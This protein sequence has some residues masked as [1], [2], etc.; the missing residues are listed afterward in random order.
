MK[1]E[2]QDAQRARASVSPFL[3]VDYRWKIKL[4]SLLGIGQVNR[5]RTA[6]R[7]RDAN[8]CCVDAAT[9]SKVSLNADIARREKN[10]SLA[11]WNEFLSESIFF[12]PVCTNDSFAAPDAHAPLPFSSLSA[13]QR[14][15]TSVRAWTWRV[16]ESEVE[17]V[18]SRVGVRAKRQFAQTAATRL[19][20]GDPF[21]TKDLIVRTEHGR[22]LRAPGNRGERRRLGFQGISN[23]NGR[24]D[25]FLEHR[26]ISYFVTKNLAVS[27]ATLWT[28]DVVPPLMRET[29]AHPTRASRVS[30]EPPTSRAR[31]VHPW[32][33]NEYFCDRL[34]TVRSSPIQSISQG[35]A[36]SATRR[37][38]W[39]F[40]SRFRY[41]RYLLSSGNDIS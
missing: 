37:H 35:Q 7:S 26:T 29:R 25:L 30:E 40:P 6:R 23:R 27:R 15:I 9:L 12:S 11:R 20:A 41:I 5:S 8:V 18:W 28:R 19:P 1:K 14:D 34:S 21:E 3:S 24:S 17:W 22:V 38:K 31:F 39:L 16:N 36:M 32:R 33:R 4:Y 13:T 2:K 10:R